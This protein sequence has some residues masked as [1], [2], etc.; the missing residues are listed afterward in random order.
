MHFNCTAEVQLKIYWSLFD[1]A[2][3]KLLEVYFRYI[4]NILHFKTDII[5]RSIQSSSIVK[6]KHILGLM[7]KQFHCAQEVLQIKLNYNFI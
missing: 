5:Q 1:C 4:L 6:L 2:I 3:M 7:L